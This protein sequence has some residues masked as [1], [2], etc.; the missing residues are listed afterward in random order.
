[1]R[2]SDEHEDELNLLH[3]Y[4]Y[5]FFSFRVSEMKNHIYQADY[6]HFTCDA[7]SI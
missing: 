2:T 3:F 5:F 4:I 6:Y 7:N 1:M